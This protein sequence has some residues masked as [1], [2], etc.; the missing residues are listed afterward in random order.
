MDAEAK[1]KRRLM[2]GLMLGMLLASLDQT[3]V[4]AAMP[5]I[6]GELNGL[7]IF[8]WVFTAYMLASTTLVPIFGKLSDLFGRKRSYLVGVSIF[9][10]GSMLCGLAQ[11]MWQLILFRTIQGIGAGAIT[12]I[13][14]TMLSEALPPKERGKIQGFFSIVLGVSAI[15]GPIS[16]AFLVHTINWHWIFYLNAPIALL[17]LWL[18]MRNYTSNMKWG[19]H[20]I[21]Y[22]GAISLTAGL[23]VLMLGFNSVGR[24]FEWLS[25]QALLMFG[26][27]V[28]LLVLFSSVERRAAN[29]ILAPELMR[30]RRVLLFSA[31]SFLG[32]ATFFL[33]ILYVPMFV[34]GVIGGSSNAGVIL[35]PLMI[36]LVIGST[37]GGRMLIKVPFRTL[38]LPAFVLIAAG[39]A[40]LC[41]LTIHSPMWLVGVWLVPIGIGVGIVLPLT[42]V[43]MQF[44]VEFKYFGVATSLPTFF[45]NI[46]GALAVNLASVY[47]NHIMIYQRNGNVVHLDRPEAMMSA[48]FR[49]AIPPTMLHQLQT[50]L[51]DGVKGTFFVGA[52]V[53]VLGIVAAYLLRQARLELPKTATKKP[54]P[55]KRV[56]PGG[57]KEF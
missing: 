15:L 52:C 16:G 9:L 22:L 31:L 25:W 54:L 37:F 48:S 41:F 53:G 46:G 21:D 2:I 30:N 57:A 35:I 42:T 45:R 49:E 20:K 51:T 47:L 5:T 27:G 11:T 34:Q 43:G 12:P 4:S 56:A 32:G 23:T 28:A 10:I 1:R 3:I 38:T 14:L 44:S 40:G 36:A 26:G 6:V 50:L 8:S 39:L 55:P 18:V 29:P 33:P 13:T 19:S 17:A 7:S 24:T